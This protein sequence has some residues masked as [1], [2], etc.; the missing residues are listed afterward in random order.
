MPLSLPAIT[1]AESPTLNNL[2]FR[3][4]H[5]ARERHATALWERIY[6][7]PQHAASG[8][9]DDPQRTTRIIASYQRT[10]DARFARFRKLAGQTIRQSMKGYA[11]PHLQG[12]KDG[13]PG[14]FTP[15]DPDRAGPEFEGWA[16][17][18]FMLTI[19]DAEI[20]ATSPAAGSFLVSLNAQTIGVAAVQA[21]DRAKRLGFKVSDSLETFVENVRSVEPADIAATRQFGLLRDVGFDA[22]DVMR[23]ELVTGLRTGK[24]AEEIAAAIDAK[25][26]S[27]NLTRART[28][29]RTE[30]SGAHANA[31]LNGLQISGVRTVEALVEFA[32]NQNGPAKPCPI[33]VDL[34]GNI[35]TIEAARGIIPVHPNCQCG[36]LPVVRR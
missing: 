16:R 5:A 3:L 4:N 23:D 6:A 36:W 19:L 13:K 27:I 1:L 33:C 34:A 12:V 24:A 14:Q 8:S 32:L 17:E 35:Y 11:A 18:T 25:L 22:G 21:Y 30:I 31:T 28:I 10:V 2:Y 29:A 7:Q 20:A 15:L 26:N 9:A